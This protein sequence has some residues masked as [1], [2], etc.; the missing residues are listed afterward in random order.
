MAIA[1]LRLILRK[2]FNNRWLT[3]SL[4]LGLVIAVSLVSSI[5]IY[6]SGVMQKLLIR[7]LEEHQIETNEFPGVFNFSDSFFSPVE[8]PGESFL[9]VEEIQKELTHNVGLPV[10]DENIMMGTIN[11]K[12]DYEDESRREEEKT[13]REGKLV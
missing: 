3:G 11:L 12:V 13:P 7:E 1:I 9:K 6:T 2:M 4:F 10:L 5:P 8:N